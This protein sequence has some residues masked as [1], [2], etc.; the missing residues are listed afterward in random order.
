MIPDLP[1]ITLISCAA[2][3]VF[4]P[5][6]S[7]PS[8]AVEEVKNRTTAVAPKI[9]VPT[10]ATA[11]TPP[12]TPVTTKATAAST[13]TTPATTQATAA[14]TPTTPATT[15]ATAASTPTTPVLSPD[16]YFGPAQAGYAAAQKVPDICAK[17]FC[18]C[19]CDLSDN[20]SSL[21]DCFTSD[22]GADCSIC[23]DEAI[24][25]LKLKN[26]GKSLADIQKAVD[27]HF[28]KEYQQVFSVPSEALLKYRQQR[29]WH[30][31]TPEDAPQSSAAET[32]GPGKD[33]AAKPAGAA[34]IAKPKK[35]GCCG[36]K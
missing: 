5:M 16:K 29:E 15:Q 8:S 28:L 7:L 9:P 10:Q 13:P 12:T 6:T 22:H 32:G 19:G 21:L 26:E 1:K 17:L 35:P 33:N 18:Y 20:H 25:A 30:P 34:S 3:V 2:I 11:A 23:Q 4:A 36:G 14:S 31:S 24:L 27:T